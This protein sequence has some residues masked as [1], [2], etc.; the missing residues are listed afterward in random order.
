MRTRHAIGLAAALLLAGCTATGPGRPQSATE[1]ALVTASA[2]VE[3]V[4]QQTRNVTLRD[5][6]DGTV[7]AV[8][9]GPEV[10]NLAQLEAGDVVQVDFFQS[11]TAAM[12]S[13]DD[14]GEQATALL[15]GRAPEGATPGAVTAVTTSLVVTL[16][17]YDANTGL[18]TFRTPDGLTRRAVVPP[19][20]RRFAESLSPGARVAVTLT[21]AVAVT[22]AETAG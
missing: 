20:L 8:T 4:N 1:E 14:T 22:I 9:A 17:N 3:S 7:F 16:T 21:D 6:A 12:A 5:N 11:T 18:A 13:P 10:R 19:N 2:T 15:A